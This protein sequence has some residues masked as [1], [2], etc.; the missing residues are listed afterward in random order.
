MKQKEDKNQEEIKKHP[1]ISPEDKGNIV[2][3]VQNF[4]E[5]NRKLVIGISLGVLVLAVLFFFI[6]NRIDENNDNDTNLSEGS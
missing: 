4:V 5:E 6:K 1:E 3:K 2:L